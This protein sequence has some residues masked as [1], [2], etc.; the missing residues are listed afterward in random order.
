MDFQQLQTTR[1]D[2]RL[3][4][5]VNHQF[6]TAG[7]VL[8]IVAMCCS[9]CLYISLP[10]GALAVLFA[11]LSKGGSDKMTGKAVTAFWLGIAALLSTLLVYGV[12]T[13]T[14][15]QEYGSFEGILRAYCEMTGM[16]YETFYSQL[17]PQ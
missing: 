13:Y 1:P 11:I 16:D 2:R 7:F 12:A 3:A 10:C 5:G 15:L 9:C 8:S 17:F 6:E 14:A 4:S